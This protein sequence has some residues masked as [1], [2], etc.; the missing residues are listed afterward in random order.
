MNKLRGNEEHL[1]VKLINIQGL[2][3]TK[4]LELGKLVCKNTVLCLTETQEKIRKTKLNDDMESIESLR[5]IEDKK[6]GGVMMIYRNDNERSFKKVDCRSKDC[7]Y[8]KSD[9]NGQQISFVIVYF[10]VND[11][12]RNEKMK[13]DIERIIENNEGSKLVILGDF[14][15]HV[16]FKGYQVINENGKLIIEWMEKYNLIMLN[17][18]FN[19]Q[20]EITWKRN[21]Q[22]SVIDFVLISKECY[23]IYEDM[24]IDEGQ[25]E[26][27]LSDHNLIE[28]RIKTGRARNHVNN[29]WIS[30]EYYKTDETSLTKFR[31]KVEEHLT[32]GNITSI[33]KLNIMLKDTADDT[34]KTKYRRKLIS[35]GRKVKEEAPWITEEIRKGIKERKRY[36]KLRRNATTQEEKERYG[37][38]Y[39]EEKIRVQMMVK[40]AIYKQEEK[41]TRQIKSDKSN[42]KIW[43]QIDK[44]RKKPKREKTLQVYDEQGNRLN[45]E[46][47]SRKMKEFWQNI[48]QMQRNSMGDIWNEETKV[49][50]KE[51]WDEQQEELILLQEQQGRKESTRLKGAAGIREHL[52]MAVKVE[53]EVNN[54]N[55]PQVTVIQV[56]ESIRKLKDK[57]A[58][59]PDCLKPELYKTLKDNQKFLETVT[60]CFNKI[61][62][63][64]GI[65]AGWKTS[66]T[67]MIPKK[68]KPTSS[69]FRPIAMTDISYKLFMTTA[70]KDKIEEH[71]KINDVIKETQNG[72][73]EKGRMENNLMLLRYCIEKSDKLS[74][75]LYVIAIDFSKAYDSVDRGALLKVMMDYKVHENILDVIKEIYTNDNTNIIREEGAKLNIQITS[76]I[77]QGCT[78]STTLFKLI[79]YDIIKK[80]EE[81]KGYYDRAVK[82]SALFFADDGLLLTTTEEEAGR[83]IDVLK[84]KEEENGLKINTE[85]SKIIIYQRKDKPESIR[86]IEVTDEIKYLGITVTDKEDCFRKHKEKVIERARVM[87]NMTYP[88]IKQS[89]NKILIGK[90]YWKSVV[91][92]SLLYGASILG[93][94]DTEM[95]KLQII[96]N[97]VYRT[98]LGAPRYAQVCTLRGEVGASSMESRIRGSQIKY[99]KYILENEDHGLLNRILQERREKL[100]NYWLQSSE[101]FMEKMNVTYGQ[102]KVLTKK[103]LSTK[104]KTWD[105]MQWKQE[106]KG[107]TSLTIYCKWKENIKQE[108]DLYDNR[109]ASEIMYRARTNNLQLQ[110]RMRHQGKDTQCMMCSEKIEN[111]NHFILWCTAYTKERSKDKNFQRPYIENE[112]YL[113]G[114]LLFEDKISDQ[115]KETIYKFWKIREKRRKELEN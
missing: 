96:E 88:V 5:E 51:H 73:T 101:L 29:K 70:V 47:G 42:K 86:G 102:L 74:R 24:T 99:I 82:L 4:M 109:P 100:N 110:D 62:E 114:Y 6:G 75:P 25:Q 58:A 49:E 30:R 65:P 106:V 89:C 50:Y 53:K 46:E 7:L 66:K 34:L 1:K 43:E 12:E 79:T 45:N 78:A 90:T 108:E 16:G 76:G 60:Q 38:H 8:V 40:E 27:D 56:K 3:K 83:M 52:D 14:N 69:Q 37:N 59:G 81:S 80:L 31:G 68:A 103:E 41:E 61:L 113:I 15:G 72:F 44:L 95:K 104:I 23:D 19:C 54:M 85:K 20:G 94:T 64:E 17:D 71:L 55:K 115:T 10:S 97:A 18:D 57:K 107:K 67:T 36:N 33:E 22:E 77:R 92:P 91:L 84:A 39:H 112:E 21:E 2:T 87:A 28:V 93:Y 11:R 105:S 98:I 63:G 35:E 13:K 111:I 32:G 9:G 26:F 48:Y